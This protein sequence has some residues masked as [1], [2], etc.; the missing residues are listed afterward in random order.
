MKLSR[1]CVEL[2]SNNLFILP[3]VDS[4]AKARLM[5]QRLASVARSHL[6]FHQNPLAN[7]RECSSILRTSNFDARQHTVSCEVENC[8]PRT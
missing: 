4:R 5:P 7:G 8:A 1:L 2:I 6:E 3:A